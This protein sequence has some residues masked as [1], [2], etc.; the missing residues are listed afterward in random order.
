L[1]KKRSSKSSEIEREQALCRFESNRE[2]EISFV[3]KMEGINA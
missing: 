1:L 2:V 3:A